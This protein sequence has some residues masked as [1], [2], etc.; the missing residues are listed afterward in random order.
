MSHHLNAAVGHFYIKQAGAAGPEGPRA[1]GS[2]KDS[3][4]QTE[5]R[6]SSPPQAS[7][8]SPPRQANAR[9]ALPGRS[10]RVS[11][12]VLEASTLQ[13]V[14][15]HPGSL[16]CYKNQRSRN[17]SLQRD[18]AAELGE[19]H[20]WEG[21]RGRNTTLTLGQTLGWML[22]FTDCSLKQILLPAPVTWK[23]VMLHISEHSGDLH[24]PYFQVATTDPCTQTRFRMLQSTCTRVA[25]RPS[26]GKKTGG[27]G[28]QPL[29]EVFKLSDVKHLPPCSGDEMGPMLHRCDGFRTDRRC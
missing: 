22:R 24:R 11:T 8:S 25:T 26:A 16:L 2:S 10:F 20:R 21:C 27:G 4:F 6:K 15:G 17:A 28:K 1:D 23:L 5:N 3:L 9:K 14:P 7:A 13:S 12:L 18:G 19:V 29:V